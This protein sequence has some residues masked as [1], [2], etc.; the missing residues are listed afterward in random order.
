RKSHL[1]SQKSTSGPSKSTNPFEPGPHERIGGMVA[2]FLILS[3]GNM[4]SPPQARP[5]PADSFLLSIGSYIHF[6]FCHEDPRFVGCFFISLLLS[7]YYGSTYLHPA[8]PI[9]RALDATVSATVNTHD[10]VIDEVK[11]RFPKQPKK[12]IAIIPSTQS[13]ILKSQD[14]VPQ[15]LNREERL[16]LYQKTQAALAEKPQAETEPQ[17]TP[18]IKRENKSQSRTDRA[19]YLINETSRLMP[20]ST[21]DLIAEM[22]LAPRPVIIEDQSGLED[23]KQTPY[24]KILI[25]CLVLL[26]H[27]PQSKQ[28]LKKVSGLTTASKQISYR[29][30]R[31][32]NDVR[33]VFSENANQ[34][35]VHFLG[36]HQEYERFIANL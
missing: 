8:N 15:P 35:S 7:A 24:H 21:T 34:I 11:K 18:A 25:K 29:R 26:K 5:E 14:P 4:M 9:R 23:I 12:T 28:L 13:P 31:V 17:T 30:V 27:A 22:A 19:Q 33:I 36:R 3:M 20:L 16:A 2:A 6:F 32:T 10:K 1:R